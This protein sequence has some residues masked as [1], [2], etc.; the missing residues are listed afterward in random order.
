MSTHSNGFCVIGACIVSS[1]SSSYGFAKITLLTAGERGAVTGTVAHEHKAFAAATEP[2]LTSR[3]AAEGLRHRKNG[4]AAATE[5]ATGDAP[6]SLTTAMVSAA[7]LAVAVAV[8]ASALFSG[9]TG[10][11]R[12]RGD[13]SSGGDGRSGEISEHSHR[14]SGSDNIDN[15]SMR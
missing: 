15:P 3:P 14:D 4:L 7:A 12:Q 13:S 6:A 5:A 11:N 2:A 1:S 9:N 8:T 10:G